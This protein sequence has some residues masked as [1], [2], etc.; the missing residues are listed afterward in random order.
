[1][2]PA[3]SGVLDHATRGG[4]H[5]TAPGEEPGHPPAGGERPRQILVVEDCLVQAHKLRYILEEQGYGVTVAPDGEAGLENCHAAVFDL[6]ISDI[7]M[8]GMSG[9]DLCRRVKADPAGR[10]VPV[11]L[12]TS[13]TD[14]MDIVQGLECGADNFIAKS[15]PPAY[16]LGRVK[17]LLDNRAGRTGGRLRVGADVVFLGKRLTVNSDKEQILDLLLS[18]FEDVV[19]TNRELE[20]ARS[21]LEAAKGE[22][23][24]YARQLERKVRSTEGKYQQLMDQAQ[25]AIFLVDAGGVVQEVNRRA[26]E[27]LGQPAAEVVGRP[28]EQWVPAADLDRQ[29]AQFQKLLAD[30][31]VR[32]D[33]A[34]VRRAD[35]RPV[36]VDYSA[37]LVEVGGER[38]V[39]AILHDVTDRNRLEEQLRQSQK[40]EAVGQLAG[41]VAHD[42]NNLLTIISGYSDVLLGRLAPDDPARGMVQEIGKA[43]ERAALLTRQ[44]LL[45]SRK[46]VVERRVLDL[47]ALVADTGTMLQRLIGEDMAI[48]TTL[49]PALCRVKGDAGQIEQILMN[50]AVNAR[51]AMPQGGRLSIETHNVEVGEGDAVHPGVAPGRYVLLAV[52]DTGCGM[53]EATKAHIFE[54]FFTTKEQGKGTGLG[55]ATV[56][57]IVRQGG[58]HIAV[59]SEVGRGTT[60]RIYLQAVEVRVPSGEPAPVRGVVRHGDETILLVEDEAAVRGITRLALRAHGYTVLEAANGREALAVCERHAGPIH[61][62]VTDV[63][64]PEM[65]GREVAERLAA[66]RPGM[67]V[68][69]LS[70]YTDDAVVRHGISQASVAFLQ[71]PFTPPALAAKAREVL[72]SKPV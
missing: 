65:G 35:G 25:D 36:C 34:N 58:G 49:D 19:R 1:M 62:V 38:V 41:G 7:Q 33:N 18:T 8:P 59:S 4:V 2:Q 27:L 32:T 53:S 69:F 23:E 63:V 21:E 42:F 43:G 48:V 56:F 57:G 3:G 12:V 11:V 17:T 20:T 68:L 54:P 6:V 45:F 15:Q 47:N 46:A 66:L 28:Y 60:F 71:K 55:L 13:L 26:E 61:L 64:M 9:F 37:S 50:L 67:R 40:M 72:D 70:G 52:G 29:R 44:L 51:D 16:L 5:T 10:N 14:P 30:G 39:L 22:V 31:F 24:R